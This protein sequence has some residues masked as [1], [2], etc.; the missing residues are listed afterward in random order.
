VQRIY[1]SRGNPEIL[2]RRRNV[3][4]G[5]KRWDILWFLVFG[6]LTPLAPVLA[7]LGVRFGWATL[8][9]PCAGRC[10]YWSSGVLREVIATRP[11]F[12]LGAGFEPL[13]RRSSGSTASARIEA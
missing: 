2:A 12:R 4:V 6:A 9:A 8:P 3:G 10:G 11:G 5:T 13:P 7:G 1:V